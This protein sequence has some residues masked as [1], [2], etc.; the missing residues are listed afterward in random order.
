MFTGSYACP[1][2]AKIFLTKVTLLPVHSTNL[3]HTETCSCVET[4]VVSSPIKTKYSV[5]KHSYNFFTYHFIANLLSCSVY[6]RMCILSSNQVLDYPGETSISS[7]LDTCRKIA[8]NYF[9]LRYV[10][11]YNILTTAKNQYID[12]LVSGNDPF[13]LRRQLTFWT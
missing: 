9:C 13:V 8:M 7:C 3:T 6:L 11:N 12:Y 2:N 5:I 4:S 1:H 10:P